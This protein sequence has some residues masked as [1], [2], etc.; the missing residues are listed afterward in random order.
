ME[1]IKLSQQQS[2]DLAMMGFVRVG[3]KSLIK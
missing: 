3:G 2:I 1:T